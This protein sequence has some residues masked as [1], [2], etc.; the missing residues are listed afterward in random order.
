[1]KI[2][3]KDCHSTTLLLTDRRK[4]VISTVAGRFFTGGGMEKSTTENHFE[5]QNQCKTANSLPFFACTL[6]GL[7]PRCCRVS[8]QP[9][10]IGQ[11]SISF[12]SLHGAEATVNKPDCNGKPEAKH[13]RG[14]GM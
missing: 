9:R 7:V 6:R 11:N 1:M 14:L 5:A 2:E 4:I 10:L 8:L 13:E 12:S 3:K